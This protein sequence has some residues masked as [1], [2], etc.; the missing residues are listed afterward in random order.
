MAKIDV[1]Q[2]LKDLDGVSINSQKECVIV[3]QRGEFVRDSNGNE[4]VKIVKQKDKAMTLRKIC[5][6]CLL[7]NAAQGEKITGEDKAKRYQ[8]AMKIHETKKDIDLESEEISLVKELVGNNYG[9][10]VVGQVHLM[11]EN[12]NGKKTTSS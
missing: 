1:T 6:D 5:V 9:P 12:K 7:A 4:L 8:L 2:E 3:D 10:L 11:L